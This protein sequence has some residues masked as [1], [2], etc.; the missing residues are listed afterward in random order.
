M[1][2]NDSRLINAQGGK[3]VFKI[4]SVSLNDKN[5][6]EVMQ[7]MNKIDFSSFW[8]NMAKYTYATITGGRGKRPNIA[9]NKEINEFITEKIRD[10]V[11]VKQ[12]EYSLAIKTGKM[13]AGDK[14]T[15]K[16]SFIDLAFELDNGGRLVLNPKM[17]NMHDYNEF[18]TNCPDG[19]AILDEWR[20]ST[21]IFP[22]RKQVIKSI[23][24]KGKASKKLLDNFPFSPIP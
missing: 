4:L 12:G 2:Y 11:E 18:I 22:D 7:A 1:K 23:T 13:K 15:C 9:A 20:G 8:Y 21:T 24:G 10:A 19:I 3:K 16:N 5:F 14:V 17:A 6:I